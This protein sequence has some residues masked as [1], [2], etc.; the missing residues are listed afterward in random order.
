MLKSCGGIT[1]IAVVT[2][3]P[4]ATQVATTH[5][6]EV[7]ALE[8]DRCLNSGV[9]AAIRELTAQYSRRFIL[10]ADLPLVNA[11]D[12]DTLI[13]TPRPETAITLVPDSEL[14]GTNAM[15]L[16]LP[17]TMQFFTASTATNS[18]SILQNQRHHRAN[19]AQ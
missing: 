2:R 7:L 10:H 9:T 8:N 13:R 18:I 17:S 11:A 19:D 16:S 5:G 3:C 14:N 4:R 12:I 15:L 6:A 1:G